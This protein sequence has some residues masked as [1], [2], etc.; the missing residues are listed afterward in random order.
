MGSV[1]EKAEAKAGIVPAKRKPT[2]AYNAF[3]HGKRADLPALCD[4]CRFGKNPDV[5][6][7]GQCH[8]YVEGAACSIRADIAKFVNSFNTRDIKSLQDMADA[9]MKILLQNNLFSEIISR[10]EGNIPSDNLAQ[11]NA[12]IRLAQLCKDLQGITKVSA[13]ETQISKDFV[14]S[15]FRRKLRVEESHVAS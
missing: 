2:S 8:E 13:S 11:L 5:G 6:G 9:Q 15:V 3:K 14:Q 4:Q 7:S 12:W 10:W 1:V